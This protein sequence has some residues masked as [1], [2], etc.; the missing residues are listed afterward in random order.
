M[1]C[2]PKNNY[3]D[4]T[5]LIYHSDCGIAAYCDP[6]YPQAGG[7]GWYGGAGEGGWSGSTGS[8]ASGQGSSVGYSGQSTGS[9]ATDN[10]HGQAPSGPPSGAGSTPTAS[11]SSASPGGAQSGGGSPPSGAS[12]PPSSSSALPDRLSEVDF[13]VETALDY[14][15]TDEFEDLTDIPMTFYRRALAE[16]AGHLAARHVEESLR[17]LDSLHRQALAARASASASASFLASPTGARIGIPVPNPS[18][19]KAAAVPPPATGICRPKGCR[20]N[21][22]TAAWVGLT[23]PNQCGTGTYCPERE[24]ACKPLVPLGANCEPYRDGE[25]SRTK[26]FDRC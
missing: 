13:F 4:A 9:G 12:P 1:A 15:I 7:G 3:R 11:G 18:A 5:T 14:G 20:R 24:D 6:V 2:N 8:P 25:R 26:L 10:D 19:A 16:E 21:A 23:P 17:H 22:S